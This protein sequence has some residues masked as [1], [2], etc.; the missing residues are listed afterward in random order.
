MK[1]LQKLGAIVVL[2]FVLAMSA[3]AGQTDTP[4]C[5]IP[6]PGQTE[7]PPC[8]AAPGDMATPT[9]TSTVPGDVGTPTVANDEMSFSKIAA[10]LF[11]NILPLF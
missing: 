1:K 6:E 2:T 5:P 4:P 3:F 10:D 7:T 9:V 8:G 11:L